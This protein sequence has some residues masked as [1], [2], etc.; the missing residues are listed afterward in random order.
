MHCV[1]CLASLARSSSSSGPGASSAA[2]A[3][4][5]GESSSSSSSRVLDNNCGWVCWRRRLSM[6]RLRAMLVSQV[7]GWARAASKPPA[8]R[9]TLT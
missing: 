6:A 3:T 5:S 1:S 7:S 4:A 8:A 9:Q 2:R